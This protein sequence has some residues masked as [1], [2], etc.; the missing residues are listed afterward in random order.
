M[1]KEDNEKP[2]ETKQLVVISVETKQKTSYVGKP[3]REP[4]GTSAINKQREKNKTKKQK[5]YKQQQHH[6]QVHVT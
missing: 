3:G 1:I 2:D 6:Q 4:S 5:K